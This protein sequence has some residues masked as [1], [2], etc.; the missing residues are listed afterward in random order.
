M[1]KEIR[2]VVTYVNNPRCMVH[3]MIRL[4]GDNPDRDGVKETPERVVASWKEI[5][6]G[7]HTD[8]PAL[9]KTFDEACDEMVILKDIEMTSFCE[10][11]MLPFYGK[12]HIAYIPDGK[13]IGVSKLARV[14]D[15]YAKRLQ[16]QERI[17]LQVTECLEQNLKP[18]GSACVI[19][20]QHMCIGCRGVQKKN[21]IMI[22]SSLVG[23]FK[24]DP[25]TRQ[26]FYQLI[27]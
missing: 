18:K 14:L 25:R 11:H 20:A 4:I 12:A 22:T 21:P 1:A 23:V 27:R 7:Y 24:D 16:I 2:Q 26:E 3:D 9:F 19:E 5:F 15:A 13:V 6:A 8:I 17:V 10:H